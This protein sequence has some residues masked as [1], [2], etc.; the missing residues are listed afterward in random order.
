MS[1]VNKKIM[2]YLSVI[3]MVGCF[4]VACDKWK[5]IARVANYTIYADE[6]AERVENSRQPAEKFEDI[7]S[8]VNDLVDDKLKL[9]DAYKA[10]FDQDSVVLERTKNFERGKIYSHVV[11]DQVVDKIVTEK[12]IKNRY[13]LLA[14]EWHVRHILLPA[15]RDSVA[16]IEKLKVIRSRILKGEDFGELAREFSQD[17]KSAGKNGDLGFIQYDLKKWDVRFLDALASIRV[18]HV[19]DVVRTKRGFHL[20]MV[21]R[22]RDAG[23]P[24]YDAERENIQ[25]TL[26]REN[27]STLDSAFYQ[28]RADINERYRAEQQSANVD[29]LLRLIKRIEA[30]HTAEKVNLQRDPR[31]FG[32]KLSKE[33][34]NFPLATYYGGQYVLGDFL[35][36]YNRISPMRR[37]LFNDKAAIEEFLNR[38]VPRELMIRYGYEKGLQR[39]REIKKMVLA[40]KER[41]MISRV[42]RVKIDDNTTPT[43]EQLLAIYQANPHE[44][45]EG[46]KVNVQ[47]IVISNL[48]IA[49][50]VFERAASG[51]DFDAL[52]EAFNERQETRE[53]KGVLGFLASSDYGSVSREAVKMKTGEISEPIRMGNRY[54]IIKIL[55]RQDGILKPFEEVR[56]KIRRAEKIR[57]RDQFNDEWM[58]QLRNTY[59]V[60]IYEDVIKK[61]FETTDE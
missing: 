60:V 10:G 48:E 36:S 41:Q 30:Q 37:P 58:T 20:I 25:N 59:K 5:P 38:N 7:I 52:A 3:M 33:E 6:L 40:E 11:N 39:N 54:S 2:V 46:A 8:H 26:I 53:Q 17:I 18:G 24:P 31:Q 1:V 15:S 9:I 29:S 56:L 19:S 55:D 61:E 45:E 42:R 47:E 49:N 34:I 35:D 44:Y 50:E 22:V 16:T 14:K 32:E 43:E 4:L 13:N 51:D 28:F 23:L 57:L 27:V 21:Q 12:M